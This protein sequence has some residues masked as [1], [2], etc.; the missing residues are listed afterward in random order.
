MI[1][2]LG[3]LLLIIMLSAQ[4]L[5]DIIGKS[6][7]FWLNFK[8]PLVLLASEASSTKVIFTRRFFY[9]PLQMGCL[10]L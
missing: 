10:Y 3:L 2:E 5:Y 1:K 6:L 7:C 8:W 9:S 4:N